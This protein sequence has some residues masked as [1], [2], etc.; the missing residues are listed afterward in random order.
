M[1]GANIMIER[2]VLRAIEEAGHTICKPR[3]SVGCGIVRR[4]EVPLVFDI[5][6]LNDI[7]RTGSN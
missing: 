5:N 4:D 3:E 1:V 6:K 2:K 7:W